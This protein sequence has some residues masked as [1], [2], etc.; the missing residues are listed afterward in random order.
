M[1]P[2]NM[3]PL[4]TPNWCPTPIQAPNSPNLPILPFYHRSQKFLSK[5]T[6]NFHYNTKK[7]RIT[8]EPIN[9]VYNLNVKP[10]LSTNQL[11]KFFVMILDQIKYFEYIYIFFLIGQIIQ[12]NAS[13]KLAICGNLGCWSEQ[14]MVQLTDFYI[15]SDKK[16]I[17]LSFTNFYYMNR[18]I[19]FFHLII[20]IFFHNL[21]WL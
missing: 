8:S 5:K 21:W 6:W 1:I 3:P 7:L 17:M 16:N 13:I 10:T 18:R 9:Y 15:F 19:F 4:I 14:K 12:M 2:T 20:W 11:V